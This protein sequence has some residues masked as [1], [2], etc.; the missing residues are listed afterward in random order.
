MRNS[1][2]EKCND[3][4]K[5]FYYEHYIKYN[6][7]P[8]PYEKLTRKKMA[9][10][11][12]EYYKKDYRRIYNI[13]NVEEFESFNNCKDEYNN[14]FVNEVSTFE[15]LFLY[16]SEFKTYTT[17]ITKELEDDIIKAKEEY[18]ANSLVIE[19]EKEAAYLLVGLLRGYGALKRVECKKLLEK[20]NVNTDIVSLLDHPYVRRF[21]KYKKSTGLI[22][23]HQ[24]EEYARKIVSSHPKNIIL[25]YTYEQYVEMGIHYFIHSLTEFKELQKH[26]DLFNDFM[27][28]SKD[29]IIIFVGYSLVTDFFLGRL[30][31]LYEKYS[32]YGEVIDS[33]LSLLPVY[34]LNKNTDNV[35]TEEEV[36]LYYDTMMPFLQY[37]GFY[38]DI[39]FEYDGQRY[40]GEEAYEIFNKCIEDNF[41]IVFNYIKDRKLTSEQKEIILGLRKYISGRFI[42]LKHLENGSVFLDDKNN[43]YLVKGIITPIIKMYQME[44]TPALCETFIMPFKDK[45]IYG[46]VLASIPVEIVGNMKKFL[47]NFYIE[48][49]DNIKEK[50]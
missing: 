48:N 20:L 46:S 25:R 12:V 4:V 26:E 35:L 27:K 17:T 19:K 24:L 34:Q 18:K 41:K 50:L 43:L 23:L 6:D 16:T 11:I 3:K 31:D 8:L 5:E 15:C 29:D 47:E 42:V 28:L 38:Y 10:D 32:E 40:C 14:V 7:E 30:E 2:I 44:K 13:L 33:F 37:A 45:I 21:V 49:K 36:E 22:Y 1:L 9:T 39:D